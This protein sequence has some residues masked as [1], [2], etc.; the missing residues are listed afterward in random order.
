MGVRG[1]TKVILCGVP[2]FIGGDLHTGQGFQVMSTRGPNLEEWKAI[3]DQQRDD[4]TTSKDVGH[5]VVVVEGRGFVVNHTAT[6]LELDTREDGL[7]TEHAGNFMHLEHDGSVVR[8]ADSVG[9]A[10]RDIRH[11]MEIQTS[12]VNSTS[13]G[14]EEGKVLGVEQ[15]SV[16]TTIEHPKF[17]GKFHVVDEVDNLLPV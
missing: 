9:S 17:L 5:V 13:V 6:I 14:I 2:R 12:E 3:P 7:S 4:V 1:R 8:V 16:G 11:L 10:K 15:G